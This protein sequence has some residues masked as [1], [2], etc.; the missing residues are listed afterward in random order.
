MGRLVLAVLLSTIAACNSKWVEGEGLIFSQKE[1][2]GQSTESR[3]G[4]LY[5]VSGCPTTNVPLQFPVY[6]YQLR[7]ESLEL[8]RTIIPKEVGAEYIFAYPGERVLIAGEYALG[9]TERKIHFFSMNHPW[10]EESVS[11]TVGAGFLG[12]P[13]FFRNRNRQLFAVRLYNSAEAFPPRGFDLGNCESVDLPWGIYRD[14]RISGAPGPFFPGDWLYL[15]RQE[16]GQVRTLQRTGSVDMGWPDDKLLRARK[17]DLLAW[18]LDDSMIAVA[19]MGSAKTES[20]SLYILSKKSSQWKRVEFPGDLTKFKAFGPWLVGYEA[21]SRKEISPG[22]SQ[23]RQKPAETGY[24]LDWQ[25]S[26]NNVYLPGILFLYNVETQEQLRIE[27]EQGD[28]EVLLVT[29]S[30]LVYR[31]NRIVMSATIGA[32]GVEQSQR[33]AESDEVPDIHWAFFGPS[34]PQAAR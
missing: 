2:I 10:V 27:T 29:G 15:V 3:D 14:V 6:L 30:K 8:V 1:G 26:A 13:H 7:D 28:S 12:D 20:S 5:L 25:L 16:D 21:Y 24:P 19:E 23:R 33:I 22:M 32:H 18:V 9:E 4:V 34:G 17:A 11:L 31:T